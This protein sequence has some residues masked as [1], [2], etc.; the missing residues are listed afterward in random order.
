MLI[1]GTVLALCVLFAISPTIV[2]TL[3]VAYVAAAVVFL[4]VY[5]LHEYAYNRYRKPQQE[6]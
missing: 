5:S 3:A 2:W 6:P 1:G 4:G